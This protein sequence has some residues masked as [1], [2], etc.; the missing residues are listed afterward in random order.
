[1]VLNNM[2]LK[3]KNIY[4]LDDKINYINRNKLNEMEYSD[5]YIRA[6]DMIRDF[7]GD[8]DVYDDWSDSIEHMMDC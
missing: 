2:K 8:T 3:F 1:M 7:S 5:K 4:E 6:W